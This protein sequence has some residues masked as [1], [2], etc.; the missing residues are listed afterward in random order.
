MSDAAAAIR[1]AVGN[2]VH[3]VPVEDVIYF[4]A[5]SRYTRVVHEGGEALIRTPLKELLPQLRASIPSAVELS[6]LTDR[7]TTIRASVRDV[8]IELLLAVALYLIARC[9]G[10]TEAQ[11]AASEAAT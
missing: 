10:A 1:A 11:A 8:K 4:E 2:T 7:T 3:M 5:D 6:I 9:V